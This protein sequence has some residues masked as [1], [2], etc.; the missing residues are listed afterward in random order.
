MASMLDL[1]MEAKAKM[2]P[3][4]GF[5]V[6]GVDDFEMPG[7]ELFLVGH[8][9]SKEDADHALAQAKAASPKTAYY[10]YD[11]STT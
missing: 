9:E 7:D 4:T 8:Y 2:T 1:I 5:N 3:K 10:I 6:V 11:P